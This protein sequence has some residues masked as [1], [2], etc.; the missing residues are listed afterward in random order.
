MGEVVLSVDTGDYCLW[1]EYCQEFP[2]IT[3][4]LIR[5]GC[6]PRKL[7]HEKPTDKAIVLVH[8]LT[9]SPFYM[10]AIAE[11]F[12]YVLGY[13]VYLPLLQ[14]HGLKH[15][16]GMAGVSLAHWK[17]NVLYALRTAAGNGAR[18]SIGGLSTGG[19]LGFYFAC[20]DAK[21]TGDLY[22]FSAA[23]GL[24]GGFWGILG[25]VVEFLLRLPLVQ[26]LD[27]KKPL[28]GSNPYRYDRVPLNSAK[29]LSK[30]IA[31]ING[32]WRLPQKKIAVKRIF[33]AWSEADR[34]INLKKLN[35]LKKIVPDNQFVSFVVPETA[36][37]DHA[38]VVLKESVYAVGSQPG[39]EPLET[40]NPFFA[41][42]MAALHRFEAAG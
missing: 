1:A 6:H 41:R 32:L 22:L 16:D 34:V 15:P 12:H 20:T 40:A 29:E 36:R 24:A 8:G 23:L 13:N 5:P 37:V 25:G 11:Y 18:V 26:L 19:A 10:T 42:M 39:A 31:E 14:C 38:C 28:V 3:D 30:L 27:S 17:E 21:I 4:Q 33:A 2:Q 9:D 7:L 35:G